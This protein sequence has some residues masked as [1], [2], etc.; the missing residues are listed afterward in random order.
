MSEYNYLRLNIISGYNLTANSNKI[1]SPYI[2][3]ISI[4]PTS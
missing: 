3:I 1:I 4:T 2:E